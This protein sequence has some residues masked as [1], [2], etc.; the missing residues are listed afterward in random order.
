MTVSHEFLFLDSRFRILGFGF[1]SIIPKSSLFLLL[2]YQIVDM[3]EMLTNWTFE[4]QFPTRLKSLRGRLPINLR[5]FRTDVSKCGRSSWSISTKGLISISQHFRIYI[6]HPKWL[7]TKNKRVILYDTSDTLRSLINVEIQ[8]NM[9]AQI[10][11]QDEINVET[12]W[13]SRVH[14]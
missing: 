13:F 7:S 4:I 14:W 11:M 3:W 9:E 8:I 1:T 2:T 10:N 6:N 12:F 5:E